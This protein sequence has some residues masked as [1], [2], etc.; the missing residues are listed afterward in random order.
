MKN[1]NKD[2]NYSDVLAMQLLQPYLPK[3]SF[4]PY[5]DSSL[6]F[7]SIR[8]IANDIM[9][10]QRN[11]ILEFGAG[12]SSVILGALLDSIAPGLKM[13]SVDENEEWVR[14]MTSILKQEGI[15][16]VQIIHSP[17]LDNP[18]SAYHGW[19]N[20]EKLKSIITFKANLILVDGPSAWQ[21]E[22]TM[23]RQQTVPFLL[24]NEL[25]NKNDFAIYLDDCNR[26]GEKEILNQWGNIF[27]LKP[28]ILNDSLG[29]IS[30]GD[31]FNTI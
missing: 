25:L 18:S 27:N 13:Y 26:P 28:R 30:A 22:R 17:L 7:N 16:S 2:S 19:Y 20:P 5:T 15:N 10:H 4:L 8:L 6:S 24:E 23:M 29:R 1:D 21:K 11:S 3:H 31:K 9:V 14:I 12:I